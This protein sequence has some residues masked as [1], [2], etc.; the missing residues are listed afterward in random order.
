MIPSVSSQPSPCAANGKCSLISEEAYCRQF[1]RVV[2]VDK[3]GKF[4]SSTGPNGPKRVCRICGRW[5]P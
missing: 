1:M 4:S 5:A 3:A 2:I